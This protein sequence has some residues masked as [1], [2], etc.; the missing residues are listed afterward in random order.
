MDIMQDLD[1]VKRHYIVCGWHVKLL[2]SLFIPNYSY[3]MNDS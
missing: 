1:L 3:F 2:I